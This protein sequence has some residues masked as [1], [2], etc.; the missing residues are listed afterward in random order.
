MKVFL[1]RLYNYGRISSYMDRVTERGIGEV[2][3]SL[4]R[5]SVENYGAAGRIWNGSQDDEKW[6]NRASD[7]ANLGEGT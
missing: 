1:F 2:L 4:K 5:A 6:Y 3:Q 7:I